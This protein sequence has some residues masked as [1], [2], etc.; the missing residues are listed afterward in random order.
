MGSQIRPTSGWQRS[1][2]A[3]VSRVRGDALKRSFVAAV[4]LSLITVTTVMTAVV[5]RADQIEP[6]ADPWALQL[7][8]A[9]T[10]RT[11]VPVRYDGAYVSIPYPGGDVPEGTGV[12]TDLVIRSYRVLG[13]D[14]QKAVHEDM[15]RAFG[16]YPKI[17][18]LS[19]PDRNIDHRRVPN[20][21]TFLKRQ[22]A[23]IPLDDPLDWDAFRPGDLVTFTVAGRL[24]HIGIVSDRRSADGARPLIL[25]NIGRGPEL[26]DCI[27]AHELTGHYRFPVEVAD[28]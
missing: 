17:W 3:E 20:L 24:P 8:E 21:R 15:T 28:E 10:A 6:L 12:C 9:A 26:E 11:R 13:F 16:V 7:V 14:L 1:A 23:E 27:D 25:H 18:G 2:A 4:V 5:T 22:G 19:R